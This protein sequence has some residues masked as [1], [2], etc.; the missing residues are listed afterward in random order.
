MWHF[1]LAAG[2]TLAVLTAAGKDCYYKPDSA[3]GSGAIDAATRWDGDV[4]D[5]GDFA[6]FDPSRFSPNV[7]MNVTISAED[8]D[9]LKR[10]GRLQP[11]TA[12]VTI[13]FDLG[14]E[15]VSWGGQIYGPGTFVKKGAGAFRMTRDSSVAMSYSGRLI[16]SNGLFRIGKQYQNLT[17]GQFPIFEVCS[18]GVLQ[19]S[20]SITWAKGLCGNGSVTNSLSS[21]QIN[22]LTSNDTF[23]FSGRFLSAISLSAGTVSALMANKNICHQ[24][25]TMDDYERQVTLRLYNGFLGA[26]KFGMSGE[27]SSLGGGSGASDRRI[28]VFDGGYRNA[29]TGLVNLGTEPQ[30]TDRSIRFVNGANGFIFTFD[31]GAHGGVTHQGEGQNPNADDGSS[32]IIPL[33]FW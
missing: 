30:T 8:W 32:H 14:D 18:P 33:A 5:T 16:V 29:K 26:K 15:D 21:S 22:F 19:L 25:F 7:P 17:D 31:G 27:P 11:R 2:T 13:T 9:Y 23:E 3:G 10:V 4:P 20:E 24:Y 1:A 6:F 28:Y 12:T